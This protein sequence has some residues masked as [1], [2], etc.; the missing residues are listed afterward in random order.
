[1]KE[2]MLHMGVLVSGLFF[3]SL[4]CTVLTLWEGYLEDGREGKS[5]PLFWCHSVFLQVKT[6]NIRYNMCQS[7]EFWRLSYLR[8]WYFLGSVSV[9]DPLQTG[10]SW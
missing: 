9:T 2:V 1:M 7:L 10:S 4:F 8:S 5:K 3:H 6:F